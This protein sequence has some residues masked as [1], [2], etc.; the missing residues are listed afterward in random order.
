[1]ALKF[2]AVRT[3]NGRNSNHRSAGVN[4]PFDR[5]PAPRARE[6]HECTV[7]AVSTPSNTARWV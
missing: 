7:P 5:T 3:D 6:N 4:G 2:G 1:M